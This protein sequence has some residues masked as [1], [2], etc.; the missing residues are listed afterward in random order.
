[1]WYLQSQEMGWDCMDMQNMYCVDFSSLVPPDVQS[2]GLG[3]VCLGLQNRQ[4]RQHLKYASV[5]IEGHDLY[6]KA[7]PSF[8][9]FFE[10]LQEKNKGHILFGNRSNSSITFPRVSLS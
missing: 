9:S 10:Y 8:Y 1:M 2:S 5:I 3:F 7:T 4:D 6:W